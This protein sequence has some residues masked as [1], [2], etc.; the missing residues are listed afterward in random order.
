[1]P[2][3]KPKTL[4]ALCFS[5]AM[6]AS[7]G[8]RREL[9]ISVE[10]IM[11]SV[12]T[13]SGDAMKGRLPLSEEQALARDWLVQQLKSRGWEPAGSE[14]ES[15]L[16]PFSGGINLVAVR[17]PKQEAGNAPVVLL[18]A[19]YDH[20]GTSCNPHPKA[21]SEVCNGAADN[22][23]SVAA[24]LEVADAVSD[25]I[26]A[27]V[28]L[29]FWDC[30][31]HGFLGSRHFAANPSFDTGSLKLIINLDILGLNLFKGMENAH[32][33]IGAETGG[34]PLLQKILELA[35][36]ESLDIFPLSFVFGYYRNDLTSFHNAGYRIP[37]V[38]F[39]DGDGSVYHSTADEATHINGGK[40]AAVARLA[41]Q[42]TVEASSPDTVFDRQSPGI[43]NGQ[44]L[45]GFEDAS[46]LL[47]LV[48]RLL[49]K[50]S[51]N[52]LDPSQQERLKTFASQL[53]NVIEAGPA[54]FGMEGMA[55]VGELGKTIGQ[56]SRSLSFIP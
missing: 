16:Q 20:L 43:Q 18:S 1:M 42:L 55:L 27:P 37:M 21:S 12:E 30:E 26:E 6:A 53:R 54:A 8:E 47:R 35:Q 17:Q 3:L 9:K 46:T 13:L 32:F 34:A 51:E 14:P 52:G 15:Y 56:Y 45:P 33:A 31:E 44:P 24:L 41:A 50:S 36:S 10:N 40:A 48:E 49:A 39:S 7:A 2:G 22:A 4:V 25:D 11:A 5:L 19:H 28:A 23:A 38:L 29:A